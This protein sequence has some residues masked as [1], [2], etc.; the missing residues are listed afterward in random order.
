MSTEYDVRVAKEKRAFAKWIS[1]GVTALCLVVVGSLAG[2]PM[3]N[4]YQQ[5][6]EGEA[7][8]AEA[9]SSRQIAISEAKAKLEASSLLAQ[10]DT[11]RAHGVAR[12]N[13]IIGASLRN[14]QAYLHWLWIDNIEKNPNAVIYIPTEANLPILEAG[15]DRRVVVDTSE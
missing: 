11:I 3:Y 5:K 7:K 8:L 13:Q 14:N 2:C 10:A 1:I 12:S 9:Q 15:R 6:K 4:V